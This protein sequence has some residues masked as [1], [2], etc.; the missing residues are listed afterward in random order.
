MWRG[1]GGRGTLT[2]SHT[3]RRGPK[4]LPFSQTVLAAACLRLQVGDAP[5]E[6][7]GPALAVPPGPPLQ[8]HAPALSTWAAPLAPPAGHTWQAVRTAPV[9][10]PCQREE[11]PAQGR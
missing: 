1:D 8:V 10:C 5:G 11:N 2:Q 3:D 7:T 4:V 9:Q 6:R